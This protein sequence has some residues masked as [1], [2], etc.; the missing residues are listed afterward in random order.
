[1]L[2]TVDGL[3]FLRSM[4]VISVKLYQLWQ[5]VSALH[6]EESDEVL[7]LLKLWVLCFLQNRQPVMNQMGGVGN[8]NLP[9]RSNVSTQVSCLHTINLNHLLPCDFY[10]LFISYILNISTFCCGTAMDINGPVKWFRS[11]NMH[12]LEFS[13]QNLNLNPTNNL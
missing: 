7:V 10:F 4:T 12:L 8:M 5:K 11:R 3:H 9:L 6:T 1:M 13:S 2:S